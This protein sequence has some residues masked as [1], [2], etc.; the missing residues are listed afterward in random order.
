MDGSTA[1]A[2]VVPLERNIILAS[3]VSVD[4]DDEDEESLT[5]LGSFEWLNWIGVKAIVFDPLVFWVN[6]IESIM[7]RTTDPFWLLGDWI[8]WFSKFIFQIKTIIFPA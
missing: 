2:A 6:S 8:S 1:E 4:V 5:P 3:S 7:W